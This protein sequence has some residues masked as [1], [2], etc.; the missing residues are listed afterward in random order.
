MTVLLEYNIGENYI[1]VLK[2]VQNSVW[3]LEFLHFCFSLS[4]SHL[5]AV[6]AWNWKI[7]EINRH[8][9]WDF[10]PRLWYWS[11]RAQL[12]LCNWCLDQRLLVLQP[13]SLNHKKILFLANLLFIWPP[14]LFIWIN[15]SVCL[16]GV[17]ICTN[18]WYVMI[19]GDQSKQ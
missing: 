6:S 19:S 8:L 13:T 10:F 11:D 14:C 17:C 3:W 4:L 15:V 1:W 16:V 7:R 12:V 5:K 2:G 18:L 9:C